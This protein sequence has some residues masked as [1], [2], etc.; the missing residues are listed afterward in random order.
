MS[1]MGL[2]LIHTLKVHSGCND[3]TDESQ[4]DCLLA[5]DWEDWAAAAALLEHLLFVWS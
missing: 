4:S 5:V 2:A 1:T 3:Q